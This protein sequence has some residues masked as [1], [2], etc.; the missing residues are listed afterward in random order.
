MLRL[1]QTSDVHLGARHPLLGERAGDQRR[2]QFEAFERTVDLAASTPVE[3]FIIAGDLFDSSFQPRAS[4]ERVGAALGR[5][6]AAGIPT[7]IIPGGA[8]APGRASIYNAYDLAMLSGGSNAGVVEVLTSEAPDASIPMLSVR[9]TSRF[10]ASDLAD[11]GWRIA[12]VHGPTRPR[13]DEI[14]ASGVDYLA[15]GGP[16]VA[17]IGRAATVSWGVSGPPELVDVADAGTADVLLVTLDEAAT[18]PAIERVT[19]G[20]T[21]VERLAID[22]AGLADQARLVKNLAA[23]ADKDLI[24][25]VQLT[26]DWPDE[27]DI[28][29]EGA[30]ADLADRFF[31]L[32]IRNLGRP[33]LSAG[34]LPASETIAGAFLRDLEGRIAETEAAGDVKTGGELREALRI[35]R[36]LLA[37]RRLAR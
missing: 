24:L 11:D 23:V 21:R 12:V 30:E 10:P 22:L 27:L 4:M 16:H 31:H 13:D 1:L 19:V 8:D 28:D 9:I 7:I 20:R 35:G 17:E 3:L 2:R 14:A 6:V 32:R 36:R 33:K 26:G 18:R 37:G 15:I 25:D 29:P 5:L 34:K